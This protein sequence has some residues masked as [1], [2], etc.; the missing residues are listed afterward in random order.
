MNI[1]LYLS[2]ACFI[3]QTVA[4]LLS[5]QIP[6]VW[7][8]TKSSI[9][10]D[11]FQNIQKQTPQKKIDTIQTSYPIINILFC[12]NSELYQIHYDLKKFILKREI[13]AKFCKSSQKGKCED[14]F[15][16]KEK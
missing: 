7:I 6:S 3:A 13:K 10:N 8:Q 5:V 2:N 9:S 16:I 12:A 11:Y 1:I 4:S 14:K 15:I